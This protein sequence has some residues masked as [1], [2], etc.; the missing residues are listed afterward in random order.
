[1]LKDLR[2]HPFDSPVPGDDL[3]IEPYEAAR[4]SFLGCQRKGVAD[5][6]PNAKSYGE[7]LRDALASPF[8][9]AVATP[10]P[11]DFD[12]ALRWISSA[13]E[14]EIFAHWDCQIAQLK[15]LSLNPVC[16]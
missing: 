6:L 15:S 16:S 8:P 3:V 1:M 5:P 14:S 7:H 12:S 11:K 13:P 2:P 9:L 4:R 10:L